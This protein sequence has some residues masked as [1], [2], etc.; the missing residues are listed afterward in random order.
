M[1][2][3]KLR[4][5]GPLLNQTGPVYTEGK[6]LRFPEATEWSFA[7][8]GGAPI[9]CITK[10]NAKSCACDDDA[11]ELLASI[12]WPTVAMVYTPDAIQASV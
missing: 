8:A 7:E 12:P 1:V 2:I 9:L 4:G 5:D 6:V 10:P 11:P 3:V